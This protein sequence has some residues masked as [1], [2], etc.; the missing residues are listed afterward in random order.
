MVEAKDR[1]SL[2]DITL[3]AVGTMESAMAVAVANDMPL[4]ADLE[5]GQ[6][7]VIPAMTSQGS[8]REQ[9]MERDGKV[10]ESY[11]I[12]GEE[13]AT[14]IEPEAGV[15]FGGIGYMAVGVDFVVS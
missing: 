5:D 7:I 11:A 10:V 12:S 1:Q 13:P 14:A 9:A 2:L 15:K 4:T 8:G 6:E 3:I